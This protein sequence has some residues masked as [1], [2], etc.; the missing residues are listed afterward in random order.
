MDAFLAPGLGKQS[1]VIK[2]WKPHRQHL[3]W[4]WWQHT[5]SPWGWSRVREKPVCLA[6]FVSLQPNCM[7]IVLGTHSCRYTWRWPIFES[8]QK[9]LFNQ[10]QDFCVAAGRCSFS[11]TSPWQFINPQQ[12]SVSI[13]TICTQPKD[14]WDPKTHGKDNISSLSPKTKSCQATPLLSAAF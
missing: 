1:W 11:N 2:C 3:C 9:C 7:E 5:A 14:R 4:G 8:R 12:P 10:P 13:R 6:A